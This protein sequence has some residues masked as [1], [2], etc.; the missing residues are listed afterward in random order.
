MKSRNYYTVLI[1]SLIGFVSFSQTPENLII[2]PSNKVKVDFKKITIN[3]NTSRKSSFQ[4]AQRGPID[5]LNPC[6]TDPITGDC[7]T[8]NNP[9]DDCEG[10]CN[11]LT[12]ECFDIIDPPCEG[13]VDPINQLTGE[14]FDIINPPTPTSNGYAGTTTDVF[15]VS[16]SG[17]ANYNVPISLPPGIKDMIPNISIIFNSQTP[18]GLAGWGWNIGGLSTITRMPSTKYHE[19]NIDGVDFDLNDRFALDGQRLMLKSGNYGQNGSEYQTENYS[20]VKIKAYGTSPYGSG[21]GPSYFIV[22]HPDGTRSYYGNAGGS[23]GRLEWT[24]Y[25]TQDPQ[26]NYIEYNYSQS[27]N[28]L[29][30]NRIRYGSRIGTT[31]PNDIYFYY[32]NRTRPE[33]SYI[34]GHTFKRT[35][36]LDRIEVKGG[37]QLYRKYQLSH[38]TTSLGYQRVSSIKEYNAAN[39][40]FPAITFSYDSSSSGSAQVH[41][42]GLNSNFNHQTHSIISGEFNGDGKLDYI[43]YNKNSPN[44]LKIYDDITGSFPFAYTLSTGQFDTAFGSTILSWNGKL[45]PQQGITTVKETELGIKTEVRFRTYALASFGPV[46]QYD[47]TAYL[48]SASCNVP[49]DNDR[50]IPKD[51]I[52][53]DFNGDGLTDVLVVQKKY[54]C[55]SGNSEV[56]FV[57]LKRDVSV[58]HVPIQVGT[59]SNRVEDSTDRFYTGDFNGDGRTDL[60]HFRT[61]K[62]E[63][64]ELRENFQ[65]VRIHTQNDSFININYPILLADFNGDGKTD[66]TIPTSHTA[67]S[68]ENWRFYLSKG[69][70]IEKYTKYIQDFNHSYS[71]TALYGQFENDPLA[72]RFALFESHYIAK[73]MDGD[74]KADLVKNIVITSDPI[75]PD[76]YTD[77]IVRIFTNKYDASDGRSK[78][79]NSSDMTFFE[80]NSG[81]ARYGIPAFIDSPFGNNILEYAYISSSNVSAFEFQGD[82]LKDV[83][84]KSIS[85]NGVVTNIFY[86][87][88]DSEFGTSTYG[89][90]Y[91]QNYPYTNV[92]IAPTFKLVKEARHTGSG[93]TQKQLYQYQGAV[94]HIGGLGFIGFK[95]VR[96]SNWFGD[97]VGTLWNITSH[98]IQKRGAITHQW[99]NT[100]PFATPSTTNFVNK[101]TYTYST[102]LLSNKVFVN[103]PTQIL[104]E[105]GLQNFSTTETF[106]YDGFKNP[107]SIH[108]TFPNGSKTT[109]Y[110][111]SNNASANNQY[112]HIG[113]LTNKTESSILD[114]NSFSSEVQFSYNNNLVTQIKRK[115]VGTPWLNEIFQYDAFGNTTRETISGS[116]ISNRVEEFEYDAGGRFMTK[117][118]DVFGLETTYEYNSTT[119]NPTT[120]TSPYGQIT[121]YRYDSW[122]RLLGEKN[123][124]GKEIKHAYDKENVSGIGW[125]LTKYT[126]YPEGQ[127]EK[128]YY[129]AFGWIIQSKKLSLNDNWIQKKFEFDAL[130]RQTRESEPY[131][132][133]GTPTQW[134]TVS[135]DAYGRIIYHSRFNGEIINTSYNGLSITVDD[136]TKTII[137]T[138]DA[139]GNIVSLQDPGG[140]INYSY[141]GNG[142]MKSANYGSHVVSTTIDGWGRKASLTDPSAGTYTYEYNILGEIL[143]ETTPKGTTEY[144]YDNYGRI[145]R[146]EINGDNTS[147]TSEYLYN[148]TTKLLTEI[149]G[150]NVRSGVVNQTYNYFYNYDDYKRVNAIEESTDNSNFEKEI[151]YDEFGRISSERYVS[152]H[153]DTGIDSDVKIKKVYD[154]AGI[155]SEI[156]DFNS[157]DLLWKV[158]EQNAREQ[159][160]NIEIGN[161]ITKKRQYDAYGFLTNITDENS[162]GNIQAL[163]LD[164]SFDA[165]RG[166]LNSRKNYGFTNW[167]ESFTHDN[168]DRLTQINGA[169]SQ[170]KAYDGRGRIT[171]NSFVGDYNYASG[172]TYRLDNIDLNN[173]GDIYY[174]QHSL[175]QIKYNA[176]KKPVE[177]YE[178]DKGRVDFEYGPMMNRTNAYYGGL[179]INKNDRQYHKLYSSIIPSEIVHDNNNGSTKIITYVGGDAYTSPIAYIKQDGG[180]PTD[181]YHYLH[182]DYLGSILAITDSFAN[183]LEQLQFGAWGVTDAFKKEGQLA[184]FNHDSLIGRGFTGHEHFFEVS[185]IHMN[186]RMYDAHLGRFLSPDNFI[187]DIYNTQSYNRFGYVWN[188]PLTLSDPG[189]EFIITAIIIGAVV[190]AYIGGAQANGSWNPLKWDWGSGDTWGGIIGGA[191]IGGVAG[192]VGAVVGPI[193]AGWLSAAT[194]ISGGIIGGGFAGLVGG[195]AGGFISGFGMSFLPGASGNAFVNGIKGAAMGGLGGLVLGG[196]IGGFTT[197]KG[198]SVLTGN[199]ITPKV[200]T[201][202]T[203]KPAT[204]ATDDALTLDTDAISTAKTSKTTTTNNNVTKPVKIK[205]VQ[206]T[207]QQ[208]RGVDGNVKVELVDK[209]VKVRHHT[210]PE[211][212]KSIKASKLIYPSRGQPYGVDVEVAPFVNPSD[213]NMGQFGKGAYIEFMVP[214]SQLAPPAPGYLGGTGEAARIITNGAPLDVGSSS[215]LNFVKW[216]GKWF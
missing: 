192:A 43:T 210:S 153:L 146:K 29:R 84:L 51:Y 208:T 24:L 55:S 121:R 152:E 2:D 53:G 123:Y 19:S 193:A 190:G 141:H 70:S 114:G 25:R 206:E 31:P 93:H 40:S 212:L 186:G 54:P 83:T 21:Y 9:C 171:N 182:R 119:G 49:P 110:T 66:F 140:T 18:N 57:D 46:F 15:N 107:T 105:D 174:Q 197:P 189:G 8:F 129:N 56:F 33:V 47:K 13:I 132:S 133:D 23:R 14:C 157:D 188:N 28:L 151:G 6:L 173:Q 131:F 170:T 147:L 20:N 175:Q 109:N 35:N 198:H 79:T 195:A 138:K 91:S 180:T 130:G 179:E 11:E 172:N 88:L 191:A 58:P 199:K 134:N 181:E 68:N 150:L 215:F 30:V 75:F 65:L 135:Y 10:L 4:T 128:V 77:E 115:G 63:V 96:Q 72:G 94:S 112:Y 144:F 12:G 167:N 42:Y 36:I 154:T 67:G 90:D 95:Q 7:I 139:L 183:I 214:K 168:L 50:N 156:R 89:F 211:A 97:G 44:Q 76:Y 149:N 104:K 145:E 17:A 99:T 59:L 216:A 165:Q 204:V 82:H 127:D 69:N 41:S 39:Q 80:H 38:N 122:Q 64:Y 78:F 1:L 26:G 98:D 207:Y 113:R 71:R 169:V 137:T 203:I 209:M 187:Q 106:T 166:I 164:Y 60:F 34:G 27:N 136:G 37:G 177:I 48:P 196:I 103:I 200:E 163:K 86:E 178:E 155:L 111:Y 92:N 73:D 205:T 100:S 213:A 81:V 160:L 176:F 45:L 3:K 201:V 5:I 118:K 120:V 85:N 61:G 124:L 202:S 62:L 116:G 194:G 158:N 125:C 22:F 142:V 16:L 143:T 52:T 159:D 126:D 184:E 87:Y 185:L 161:G 108:L 162:A 148:P 117:N 101:T 102:Q 32:K 74:G